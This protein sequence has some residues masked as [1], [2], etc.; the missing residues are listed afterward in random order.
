MAEIEDHS[1]KRAGAEVSDVLAL[2]RILN[3]QP[4]PSPLR[5]TRKGFG[6][7]QKDLGKQEPEKNT[8]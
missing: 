3:H 6:C 1:Q 7:K 8:F 2:G 5:N 4:V